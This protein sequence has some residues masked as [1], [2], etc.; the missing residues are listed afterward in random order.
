MGR[1]LIILNR[2]KTKISSSYCRSRKKSWQKILGIIINIM[3]VWKL[4]RTLLYA[5][6]GSQI[7]LFNSARRHVKTF[8]DLKKLYPR[9]D[10]ISWQANQAILILSLSLTPNKQELCFKLIKYWNVCFI[11][12]QGKS[13]ALV[14]CQKYPD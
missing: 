11:P 6:S 1:K 9:F 7:D 13:K 10:E 4:R 14:D 2:I 8:F 12:R 3:P 5:M